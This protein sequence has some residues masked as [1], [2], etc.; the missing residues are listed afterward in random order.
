MKGS[1]RIKNSGSVSYTHLEI[2]I[3]LFAQGETISSLIQQC[4]NEII[5]TEQTK[6]FIL[7]SDSANF[8]ADEGLSYREL[9]LKRMESG[10][11]D[12][13][14]IIP[15]E[16]VLEFDRKGYIYDLAQMD[17][18]HNL[19]EDVYKRQLLT[20]AGR[21]RRTPD[22]SAALLQNHVPT[23]FVSSSFRTSFLLK[24]HRGERFRPRFPSVSRLPASA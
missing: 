20:A 1:S 12:D 19:S 7:Y 6:T 17:F 18:V 24:G 4:F 13:L 3:T 5:N 14:Y 21:R 8:Y 11:A 10:E 9:L 15:A 22:P 2:V 16:D 23:F